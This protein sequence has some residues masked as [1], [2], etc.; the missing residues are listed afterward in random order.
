MSVAN[1][2]WHI[3]NGLYSPQDHY[4]PTAAPFKKEETAKPCLPEAQRQR[5]SEDSPNG[6]E[7]PGGP[8]DIQEFT[9]AIT[10]PNSY[11]ELYS[12]P[13][14]GNVLMNNVTP[15]MIP[16]YP[17]TTYP[18]SPVS[19]LQSPLPTA[20][21]ACPVRWPVV[22]DHG[23]FGVSSSMIPVPQ[24]YSVT[25]DPTSQPL[26]IPYYAITPTQHSTTCYEEYVRS[27]LPQ[28]PG[29]M[30]SPQ[31]PEYA[32]L[33]REDTD[34]AKPWEEAKSTYHD[35]L[36]LEGGDLRVEHQERLLR[37]HGNERQAEKPTSGTMMFDGCLWNHGAFPL[38]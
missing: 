12:S 20:T 13:A 3:V 30:Y 25:S 38:V 4:L 33:W 14:V 26:P 31:S 5:Q 6:E 36:D 32:C 11:D 34:E 18:I 24:W 8:H 22:S 2:G 28:T 27:G 23:N 21:T 9:N 29:S 37:I 7:N 10:D 19:R 35:L 1:Q 17:N 16:T 15:A